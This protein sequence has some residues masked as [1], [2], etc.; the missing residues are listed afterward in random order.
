MSGGNMK[1][2]KRGII[3]EVIILFACGTLMIG[4][5]TYFTQHVLTDASVKGQAEKIASNMADETIAA[6]KEYPSYR[7]LI[8]YW[9][10]HAEELD[11]EYD[12]DYSAGTETEKKIE[13]LSE[14]HPDLNLKYAEAEEIEALPPEDQKLYAEITYSWLITRVDQIKSANEIAFLFGVLTSNNYK[15]Q[16]FL[17]SGAD[18]GSERGTEYEQVYTIGVTSE[19]SRGQIEGMRQAHRT[20]RQLVDAGDYV[21][22]YVYVETID[23]QDLMIGLTYDLSELN[24]RINR[25][26]WNGT[27][28]AMILELL[29]AWVFLGM[30][31][32]VV[33][34]PLKTIQE[35]IRL[36]MDRKN[37]D[38]ICRNLSEIKSVNEIGQLSMDVCN[39]TIEI[40]EHM[41]HI[42]EITSEQERIKTELSLA[43]NIQSAMLPTIFPAFPEKDEFDIFASMDPA[44]DVGG[45]F[46]NFFLID[47]DHLCLLIADVA[48]KGIP[49]AMF[50]MA[51]QIMLRNNGSECISPSEIMEKTN[52]RIC[53][54]NTED[55]FVTIWLGVLE[56]S[57]GKLTAANAGHEYPAIRKKDG[58]FEL[59]KDKHGMVV[60]AFEGLKYKEYEIQ[61]EPGD[62]IF[63]YTDGVVE[64][65]D[66]ENHLFG[67][68]RMIEALNENA[69][70]PLEVLANVRK[71]VDE[72]IGQAEQFDDLTM[73]CLEYKGEK[74]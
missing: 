34:Q 7:W 33:L 29:L 59:Y 22:Y 9:R 2:L 64:A 26:T 56:I 43:S 71:S 62:K 53:A 31:Y 35:N 68:D 69:D 60:G 13:L 17:F 19:V 11:I 66:A 37:S 4:V 74:Q 61:L 20:N 72:F 10:D 12:V 27:V 28:L 63:V 48:G 21:D 40:D 46:Y 65:T 25:S 70:T 49:G 16:F 5:F 32:R 3:L 47:D 52:E 42:R 41:D 8:R 23:K 18:P 14:R 58:L 54:N 50:M 73:L 24:E 6:M 36:Y 67:T 38:E 51:T 39:M 15:E 45:D 1:R 44:K 55:M 30:I 57:T